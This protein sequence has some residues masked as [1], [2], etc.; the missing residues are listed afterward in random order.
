MSKTSEHHAAV[1]EEPSERFSSDLEELKGNFD[2]LRKDV[3]TL[4]S[5]ATGTAKRSAEVFRDHAATVAQDF[6]TRGAESVESAHKKISRNPLLSIAAAFGIGFI[7]AK[8]F[9]RK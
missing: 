9:L 2:Q 6:K 7:F 4:L 5:N 3:S 1:K 8:L